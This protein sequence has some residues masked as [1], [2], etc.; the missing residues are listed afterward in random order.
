MGQKYLTVING[1]AKTEID[2]NMFMSTVDYSA[3]IH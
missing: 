1:M 3:K 2:A